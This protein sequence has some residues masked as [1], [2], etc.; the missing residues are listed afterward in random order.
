MPL[1]N[2]DKLMKKV[3]VRG[4]L[5]KRKRQKKKKKKGGEERERVE[6]EFGTM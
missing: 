6:C 2:S 1:K 3:L 5:K 4:T